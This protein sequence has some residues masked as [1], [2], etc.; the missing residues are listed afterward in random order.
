MGTYEKGDLVLVSD[1]N[2][3]TTCI[4]LTE[5]YNVTSTTEYNFYYTYCIETDRYGMVYDTEI[6]GLVSKKFAPNFEFH[7]EIFDTDWSFYDYLFE[8][9]S[10]FPSFFPSGSLDDD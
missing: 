7:S 5:M 2:H 10:Y 3:S 9:F 6:I 1:S 4:I 8:A